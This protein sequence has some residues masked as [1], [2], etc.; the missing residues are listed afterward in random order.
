M[1]VPSQF[2][3]PMG[4]AVLPDDGIEIEVIED[5]DPYAEVDEVEKPHEEVI[6]R[7]D[8]NLA[9]DLTDDQETKL[10]R[11]I[12]DRLETD[13]EAHADWMKTVKTGYKL[14]GLTI[15]TR[16]NPWKDACGAHSPL[17]LETLVRFVAEAG[18]ETWPAAGPV[19][20]LLSTMNSDIADASTRVEKRMNRYLSVESPSSRT[21]HEKTLFHCGLS[22]CAFKKFYP[23]PFTGAPITEFVPADHVI[24][25][26]GATDLRS[27]PYFTHVLRVWHEDYLTNVESGLYRKLDLT[28][29]DANSVV[30]EDTTDA[31]DARD[32]ID[33]IDSDSGDTRH[34]FYEAHLNL[35]DEY[36]ADSD[37]IPRR[38]IV[39]ID[40]DSERVLS[41]YRGWDEDDATET[42]T[43][44][45]TQYTYMYGNGPYGLGLVHMLGNS[46]LT[47]TTVLRE[48][49]DAGTLANLPA[50][51]KTRSLRVKNE[52]HPLRPGEFRDV[53]VTSGTLRDS[54]FALPYKEPSQVLMALYNTVGEEA[55]RFVATADLS[56]QDMP[57]NSGSMGTLGMLEKSA[58][59]QAAVVTR[60]YAAMVDELKIIKQY[61]AASDLV[62]EEST[63]PDEATRAD[64]MKGEIVP[65]ADLN[66]SS[67]ALRMGQLTAAQGLIQNADPSI[68]NSK[69]F[70]LEAFRMIG[71][72]A[73]ERFINPDQQ[74][75]PVQPADPLS[76]NMAI[77]NTK[78]VAVGPA[79]DHEAHLKVHQAFINDPQIQALLQT[80]PQA[81][82]IMGAMDAH[83]RE[84]AAFD[85]MRRME[86]SM[87]VPIPQGIHPDDPDA[88]GLLAQAADMSLGK[89]Q[90]RA[91]AEQQA[92]Q[93]A[94]PIVQQQQRDTEIK[95]KAV[96]YAHKE[97][98][99]DLDRKERE[100]ALKGGESKSN[101]EAEELDLEA[102]RL[103]NF[104]AA[105]DIV[106]G[107]RGQQQSEDVHVKT[108]TEPDPRLKTDQ[109]SKSSKD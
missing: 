91:A 4:D 88:A 17:M 84:H 76:E 52:D 83:L 93:A 12:L 99:I 75:E 13:R 78:P 77:L 20:T 39:T 26:V 98:L 34:T 65:V 18:S 7:H 82:A 36:I 103:S 73:P 48:L 63:Y 23:D 30:S 24:L 80:S 38:Y 35:T 89:A 71:F 58:K 107:E 102:K 2:A 109:P 100:L 25:P 108:M 22:G 8:D 41:V 49:V 86:Q 70:F 1:I 55:R 45:M 19:R 62:P 66:A 57:T 37:H 43:T 21:E 31:D 15:E 56:V 14:L 79:Q 44:V 97:K 53:D 68:V 74:Q 29:R 67:Q 5:Q 46:T 40:E 87:G 6:P 3:P 95:D 106:H 92:A 16:N 96:E 69:A 11:L 50:G 9:D 72:E 47:Q 54:I 101:P 32:T 59:Y 10:A 42:P 27:S 61:L 33:G 60:I 94:D 28:E 105:Q 81:Q 90:Q 85:Y 51:Y 104:K 64:F